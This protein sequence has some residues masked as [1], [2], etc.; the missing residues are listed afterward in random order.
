MKVSIIM[1]VLNEAEQIASKLQQLKQTQPGDYEIIVVDGGSNDNSVELARQYAHRVIT[2]PR[3][4]ALQMNAGAA[5]SQADILLFLHADTM[6]PENVVDLLADIKDS[7]GWF[8]VRLSGEGFM[9]RVIEGMMNLRSRL[10]SVATGDQAIFVSRSLFN[11]VGGFPGIALMEDIAL[12]KALRQITSPACLKQQVVTSSRRW[13]QR[14]TLKTILLM[15]WLRLL[16]VFGVSPAR[17]EKL[18]R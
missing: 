3:G 2:S 17:L 13:Q 9:F 18:Y 10:T 5:C 4:R 6:L 14:G 16:Y 8:S 1:P 11:E 15:W 12:S 7:W